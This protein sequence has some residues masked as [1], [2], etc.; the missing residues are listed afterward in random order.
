MGGSVLA[1]PVGANVSAVGLSVGSDVGF[2][3]GSD[4]GFDVGSDVGFDV[5]S[6]VGLDVGFDVGFDVG[7]DVRFD[8]GSVV[9]L[10]SSTGNSE[11]TDGDSITD[12]CVGASTGAAG[13]NCVVGAYTGVSTDS[14]IGLSIGSVDMFDAGTDVG[15]SVL[16]PG[17]GF[18]VSSTVEIDVGS[19]IGF[20]V[21]RRDDGFFV[22]SLGS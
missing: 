14:G 1:S 19:A 10:A 9:G 16:D 21:G 13:A 6:D 18:S 2:D 22:G 4:V 5:G 12:T 3:V 7:L 11:D 15:L 17:V 20:D 8:V